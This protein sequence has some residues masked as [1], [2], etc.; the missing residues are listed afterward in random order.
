MIKIIYDDSYHKNI[1]VEK[2]GNEQAVE[3]NIHL[4]LHGD[5]GLLLDPGG[6]KALNDIVINLAKLTKVGNVEA[7]F[8]SHQDPDVVAA[9]N[10]WLKITGARALCSD[11]W[12]RFIPHFGVEKSLDDRFISI[13]DEGMNFDLNGCPLQIIPAH[14][15]HSVANFQI[16]DAIS[17]TL[18]SG[19][20]G[21]SIGAPYDV[22]KKF[23]QHVIYMAGFHQRYMLSN[24][25]LKLW[26]EQ[27]VALDIENI[28]PQHGAIFSGREVIEQFL[29]WCRNLQ[30]GTDVLLDKLYKL[31]S[32]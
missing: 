22:V 24:A 20:L 27:L 15:L 10:G 6:Q 8:L 30:C 2:F 32:A 4:I 11:K 9:I 18:Y 1:I 3:S 29:E 31:P 19:D 16:Y 28:V 26:L 12:R 17:K 7:I 13:P 21:T 14:F 5:K 23:Q 25:A